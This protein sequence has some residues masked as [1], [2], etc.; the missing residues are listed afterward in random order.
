MS[1]EGTANTE[2]ASLSGKIRTF[3]VD[4]SLSISGAC[5][6]A[7][8]TGDKIDNMATAA[9][10]SAVE[11]LNKALPSMVSSEVGN[12]AVKKTGDTV[13]GTDFKINSGKS[14]FVSNNNFLQLSNYSIANI[15][16]NSANLLISHPKFTTLAEMLRLNVI[17]DG[18]ESKYPVLHTGN[19]EA[20]GIA[21]VVTGS[22]VGTGT[23]GEENPN[24]LTF[25]FAPKAVFI[26]G[27]LGVPNIT[28]LGFVSLIGDMGV[29]IV[30]DAGLAFHTSFN[31]N[32][33][34]WYGG[35]GASQAPGSGQANMQGET[36]RYIA[37]G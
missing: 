22:Y 1:I 17:V 29:G 14:R 25:P 8:A 3:V 36:Y 33:V 31:G 5:A 4:K 37:I 2:Y 12:Q 10:E 32:T 15:I 20:F 26:I 21:R 35:E 27:R 30:N 6:D 34:T 23:Y 13:P 18:V 28:P 9:G 7:K 24:T 16:S 11:T 19:L